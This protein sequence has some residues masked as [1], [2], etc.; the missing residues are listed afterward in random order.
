[1]SGLKIAKAVSLQFHTDSQILSHV[2]TRDDV[3]SDVKVGV[4]LELGHLVGDVQKGFRIHGRQEIT[5][6]SEDQTQS[7]TMRHNQNQKTRTVSGTSA[8]RMSLLPPHPSSS[9]IRKEG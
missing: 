1:M 2:Q 5:D 9:P 7:E 6:E 4:H 3:V 8:M